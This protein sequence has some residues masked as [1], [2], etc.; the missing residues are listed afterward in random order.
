MEIHSPQFDLWNF[1]FDL[2]WNNAHSYT[3]NHQFSGDAD[4]L[5]M[6]R[7]V[8]NVLGVIGTSLFSSTLHGS[9]P[10]DPHAASSVVG[11]ASDTASAVAKG[12]PNSNRISRNSRDWPTLFIYWQ[13]QHYAVNVVMIIQRII[14]SKK[15]LWF[16]AEIRFGFLAVYYGSD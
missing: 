2:A 4:G 15:C 14:C 1:L 9:A 3:C 11:Y 13:V 16:T 12:E 7:K 6:R 5:V 10:L 8:S